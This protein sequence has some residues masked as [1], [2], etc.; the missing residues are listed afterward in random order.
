MREEERLTDPGMSG[1]IFSLFS[2]VSSLIIRVSALAREKREDPRDTL[3]HK[4]QQQ[5]QSMMIMM[6]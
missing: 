1:F 3:H 2:L 5:P 6:K 4:Q